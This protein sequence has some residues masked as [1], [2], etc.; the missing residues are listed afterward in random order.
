MTSCVSYHS[1]QDR[2]R[3]TSRT[4][5]QST[6]FCE[7]HYNASRHA[8]QRY[9]ELCARF[10][11]QELNLDGRLQQLSLRDQFSR[12]AARERCALECSKAR[13]LFREKWVHPFCW[14]DGHTNVIESYKTIASQYRSLLES[15]GEQLVEQVRQKDELM[16]G[17]LE[18]HRKKLMDAAETN[19]KDTIIGMHSDQVARRAKLAQERKEEAD[20]LLAIDEARRDASWEYAQYVTGSFI[21]QRRAIANQQLASRLLW[22]VVARW[23]WAM[24]TSRVKNPTQILNDILVDW[25][26]AAP[27]PNTFRPFVRHVIVRM[28]D[29]YI[30]HTETH[31]AE[32]LNVDLLYYLL[33]GFLFPMLLPAELHTAQRIGTLRKLNTSSTPAYNTDTAPLPIVSLLGIA[34]AFLENTTSHRQCWPLIM[35]SFEKVKV[36]CSRFPVEHI[37]QPHV[38]WDYLEQT[39]HPLVYALVTDG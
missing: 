33:Y 17:A 30:N 9:K 39:S 25:W 36:T 26:S 6:Q 23:K 35:R 2:R 15:I 12:C 13:T 22:A 19:I 20:T 10:D 11:E 28:V 5:E 18:Q 34:K 27:P 14:N 38:R 4:G 32:S 21:V 8:Y 1:M 7:R 31:S 37:L 29:I 16:S 24:D 3:C